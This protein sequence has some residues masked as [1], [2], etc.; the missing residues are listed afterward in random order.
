MSC[1]GCAA[2]ASGAIMS[3]PKH[4]LG[5]IGTRRP[6][7]KAKAVYMSIYLPRELLMRLEAWRDKQYVAPS[8]IALVRQI[9]TDW[10]DR[11]EKSK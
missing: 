9:I 7:P 6:P 11:Q 3:K 2:A 4:N 5:P 1:S 8:R 10:L